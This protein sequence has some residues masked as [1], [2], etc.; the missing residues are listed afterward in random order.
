MESTNNTNDNTPNSNEN[1]NSDGTGNNDNNAK[2]P[3]PNTL[4]TNNTNSGASGVPVVSSLLSP[5]TNSS[6]ITSPTPILSLDPLSL[7]SVDGGSSF[8]SSLSSSTPQKASGSSSSSRFSSSAFQTPG[9]A[10][11]SSS[12]SGSPFTPIGTNSARKGP[13]CESPDN[14]GA[15]GTTKSFLSLKQL[16]EN[17]K[18]FEKTYKGGITFL[19]RE[20]GLRLLYNNDRDGVYRH[21]LSRDEYET[22]F[23]PEPDIDFA[24]KLF[25]LIRNNHRDHKNTLKQGHLGDYSS[26]DK[27]IVATEKKAEYND[28]IKVEESFRSK[29]KG[30]SYVYYETLDHRISYTNDTSISDG[31]YEYAD[32]NAH[33]KKYFP[34]K[35]AVEISKYFKA[36]LRGESIKSEIN[37]DAKLQFIYT[38]FHH[39]FAIEGARDPASF[40]TIP[41]A[42]EYLASQENN[43]IKHGQVLLEG[44]GKNEGIIPICFCNAMMALSYMG[45]VIFAPYT[46]VQ[47][48]NAY[49][50]TNNILT[51]RISAWQKIHQKTN[52][53]LGLWKNG[54][55]DS[56]QEILK[57]LVQL[58]Q[59][60]YGFMPRM[61]EL[62]IIDHFDEIGLQAGHADYDGNCFFHSVRIRLEAI[63][64]TQDNGAPIDHV[65]LRRIG[66]GGNLLYEQD[67][68]WRDLDFEVIA[69]NLANH[70][71]INIAL[72]PSTTTLDNLDVFQN[73]VH[74]SDTLGT[75]QTIYIGNIDS[76]HFVPLT[77][78]M[79]GS[80]IEDAVYARV[81]EEYPGLY[82]N[83]ADINDIPLENLAVTDQAGNNSDKD[84]NKE[85]DNKTIGFV[86]KLEYDHQELYT[87]LF[88]NKTG[89]KLDD[90]FGFE[91]DDLL[92]T[93]F[94]FQQITSQMPIA[95]DSNTLS[96]VVIPDE[97]RSFDFEQLSEIIGKFFIW[98]ADQ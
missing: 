32:I 24:H 91:M 82:A 23:N 36:I 81:I 54:T 85:G 41:M 90:K 11:S 57:K 78:P 75:M 77:N 58:C 27:D 16:R 63:G 71:S 59:D 70:F 22:D 89:E 43:N 52:T 92:V 34:K 67:G 7:T 9:K 29:P 60:W 38:L 93:N 55:N 79:A 10:R 64:I 17:L 95:K 4:P 94:N 28:G 68:R 48:S 96:I 61:H 25:A 56:Y 2:S 44:S 19:L 69:Q 15:G 5:G 49:N 45:D 72:V 1:T 76:F 87:D 8:S 37:D 62:P 98:Y 12:A 18:S 35:F 51:K 80:E 53:L 86:T 13:R 20:L 42:L 84:N 46:S 6:D 65:Y 30:N 26:S 47:Y 21:Y 39:L 66:A 40:L 14:T 97:L 74:V 88:A 31:Y 83:D 3:N 73:H 50:S 33:I